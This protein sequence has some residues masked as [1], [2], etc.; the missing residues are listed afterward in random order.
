MKDKSNLKETIIY[1]TTELIQECDG[2]ISKITLRKISERA[3]VGLGLINYHFGS[4]EQLITL[5]VQRIINNVVMYFSPNE[6]EHSKESE[7]TDK[8]R[9]TAWAKQVYDFLFHNYAISS[10]S[11]L[12]DMQNYHSKC[13]S[14]YTQKGFLKA[15]KNDI[16]E[17]AKKILVFMLTSA[18]Q[19]AFLSADSSKE[20]LGY[21]L[22]VKEERDRY[23]ESVIEL[24]FVGALDKEEK[25]I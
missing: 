11:I 10:I 9:L 14:V 21:N 16:G 17:D 25:S 12:G 20:I 15:I 23:I 5:C 22:K 24:L 2:D 18:M 1:A 3:N 6:E 13:N 7:L 8:E 4:K 19:V